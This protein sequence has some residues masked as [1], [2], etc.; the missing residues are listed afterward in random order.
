MIS[1]RVQLTPEF[2]FEAARAIVPY[3]RQLGITHLYLSPILEARRGSTHG[4]D[5]TDPTRVRGELGGEEGLLRV[6][7]AA[8][9]AGLKVLVDVVPNHM[10]ADPASPWWRD[11]LRR[12]QGSRFASFFDI[13]WD[14]G[15]GRLI[16]PVLGRPASEAIAAGELRLDGD[17]I[18]YSDR[19]FPTA[20]GTPA[21]LGV[22]EALARQHYDL[23][24]WREGPRRINYRRF[25]D[26][27]DLAGLRMENPEAFEA[28]HTTI[29]RLMEAGEIDALRIDHVDGLLDPAGYLRKLAE[30]AGDRPIYVEKILASDEELPRAWPARGT[31][32]YE[33]LNAAGAVFVDP[34]GVA[35][36]QAAARARL[37]G[38]FQDAA[39]ACKAWAADELFGVDLGR[40]VRAFR[41]AFDAASLRGRPTD[42]ELRASLVSLSACLRVY[43]TYIAS[44]P[45]RAEDRRRV[46]EAAAVAAG[47]GEAPH[48]ALVDAML[49]RPPFD[50]GPAAAAALGAVKKWQ[51]FTGPL[52]AKGVEDTALYRHITLASLNEVGGEPEAHGDG[53]AAFHAAMAARAERWP[54]AM[55]ATATHDTKRGEDTR[56]R[57]G[58]LSELAE[59]WLAALERWRAWHAPLR[60]RLPGG[61]APSAADESLFYQS[62][63][64]VWPADGLLTEEVAERLVGAMT[65]SAR[66]AKLRTSWHKPDGAYEAALASYI[67]AVML[68]G[69]GS[70]FRDDAQPLRSAA[71]FYGAVYSLAQVA[72]KVFAPGGPDFYQGAELWDTALVDPDNRRPV[73]YAA[74]RRVL[75]RLP[76]GP[77]DDGMLG[78]LMADWASGDIKLYTILRAVSLRRALE[79]AGPL[80]GYEAIRVSGEHASRVIAFAR[81]AAGRRCVVVAP[82]LVAGLMEAGR[83]PLGGVWGD[84][85]LHLPAGVTSRWRDCLTGAEVRV[86]SDRLGVASVLRA[87]PVAVLASG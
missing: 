33:F 73:D 52:A 85:E 30:R 53:A 34:E 68:G 12:G 7:R 9:S 6:T 80:T 13:D 2:G 47:R 69:A 78:R 17:E 79:S 84:T 50:A 67:R 19:R 22:A 61:D 41:A 39:V 62:A 11:V 10:A 83:F 24:D 37:A 8:H 36:L 54:G 35:R 31:T 57:I 49:G 66:E 63:L 14:A 21:G 15:R 26:I 23:I 28:V 81:A 71:A 56:L 74:R 44:L 76:D 65:K 82:R 25:F 3:L 16:L 5:A 32:G 51:Q 70:R 43:R 45:A 18:V 60:R 27:T 1:Y 86:E 46:E 38:S 48:P 77:A 42:A 75:D 55:N 87:F 59:E 29:L 40:M 58:V 4:Y 72:L 20:P 64:G